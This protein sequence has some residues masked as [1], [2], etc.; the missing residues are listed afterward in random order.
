M[1]KPAHHKTNLARRSS[2]QLEWQ[3]GLVAVAAVRS[4]LWLVITGYNVL[5][6]Q[7]CVG[8]VINS[9]NSEEG[10]MNITSGRGPG[11][12]FCNIAHSL[13][14]SQG[15]VLCNYWEYLYHILMNS[16]LVNKS[17]INKAN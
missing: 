15:I 6:A 8:S 10:R 11:M 16:I 14:L 2:P 12:Q 13:C 4:S 3:C 9:I 1:Y 7:H 17:H 5:L